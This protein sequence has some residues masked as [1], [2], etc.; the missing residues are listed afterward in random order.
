VGR[1]AGI[2]ECATEGSGGHRVQLDNENF[3]PLDD[4]D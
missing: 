3:E 1:S 2:V 4:E